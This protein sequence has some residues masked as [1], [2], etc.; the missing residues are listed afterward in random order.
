MGTIYDHS[1]VGRSRAEHLDWLK[2]F[3]ILLMIISHTGLATSLG[4]NIL[5]NAFYMPMF[6]FVSGYF[7][8]V[9]KYS[10]STFFVR[11]V[12]GLIIPYAIW[13]II[14]LVIWM[15]MYKLNIS[16]LSESPRTMVIGLLWNNNV[17]LPIAGALWFLSC[18]F[19]VSI[20]AF[21]II[22]RFGSKVY[23]ICSIVI[24]ITGVYFHP[25]LPWSLDSAMVANLMF[26]AGYHY[27]HHESAEKS[28][29]A[30]L[31]V[32][33]VLISIALFHLG[34]WKNGFTNIRECNYG[35]IPI[36]YIFISLTGILLWWLV[37][38]LLYQAPK[39]LNLLR[40]P[41]AWIGKYSMPFLC[42]NQLV[43][44]ILSRILP[45]T[46]ASLLLQSLVTIIAISIFV[47]AISIIDK[48]MQWK[49]YST[50]FGR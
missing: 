43:I 45:A 18:L 15:G 41:V 7:L 24:G 49:L 40:Q 8:H 47:K 50:L 46:L 16:T 26:A 22:K 17:H 3:G 12:K 44:A 30:F 14:H 27:A 19:F 2:G 42:L 48:K 1:I 34:A 39:Q 13:G 21:F 20:I 29:S 10:F 35:L 28:K 6:F 11:K 25:F 4:I 5:I 31:T 36:L 33:T 23:L 9:E 38:T 37:A 32:V